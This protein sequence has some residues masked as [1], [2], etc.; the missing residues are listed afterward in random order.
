MQWT[1]ARYADRPT[2]EASIDI[3]ALPRRCGPLVSDPLVMP[4]LSTELQSVEWLDGADSPAVGARFRGHNRHEAMGE[5]STTSP[6]RRVRAA[7]GVRLG[8]RGPGPN[9][10]PPGASPSSPT[11]DGTG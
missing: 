11:G 10:P 8:R 6:R 4:E 5:W 9:R 1:G 3:A 7:A 2:V